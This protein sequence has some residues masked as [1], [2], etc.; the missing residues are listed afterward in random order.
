[1]IRLLAAEATRAR[2]R[3][4]TWVVP[5][6]TI[7]LV[8]LTATIGSL[9]GG[10][11]DVA[12]EY[13]PALGDSSAYLGWL[14]AV[15][16][17]SLVGAEFANGGLTRVLSVEPRRERVVAAK[18]LIVGAVGG[19]MAAAVL[20]ATT[21]TLLIA[22][23][24]GPFTG[25]PADVLDGALLGTTGALVGGGALVSILG[26]ALA[27]LF[28]STAAAIVACTLL[29]AL[30]EP[31]AGA[32]LPDLQGHGPF[33][34]LFGA[35][36]GPESAVGSLIGASTSWPIAIPWVLVTTGAATAVFARRDIVDG[37]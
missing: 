36:G 6:A 31:A 25:T 14:L 7:A 33:L 17:A 10:T 20:V 24:V 13:R 18:L 9:Q 23:A 29:P 26:G 11:L 32:W 21:A 1:M 16:G 8:G 28:R 4:I 3:R 19:A 12:G 37:I 27:I 15:V 22:A 30:V 34:A 2:Y 5:T 35:M